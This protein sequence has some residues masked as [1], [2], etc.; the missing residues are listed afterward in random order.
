MHIHTQ[1]HTLI[2]EHTRMETH[3]NN[4]THEGIKTYGHPHAR[5]KYTHTHTHTN[6]H[7]HIH[8]HTHTHVVTPLLHTH[9]CVE[10][11]MCYKSKMYHNGLR[12]PSITCFLDNAQ[13]IFSK[14]CRIFN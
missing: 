8:I 10:D 12:E 4:H 7:T 3:T 5:K 11:V 2:W 9:H 13:N 6:T 1:G 14:R